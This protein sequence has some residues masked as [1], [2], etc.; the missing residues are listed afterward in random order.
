MTRLFEYQ[1]KTLLVEAGVRVPW[2]R[3]VESV[4]AVEAAGREAQGRVVLKPQLLE[5]GRGRRGLIAAAGN[6]EEAVRRA[7]ELVS[8]SF[9]GGLPRRLLVEEWVT[10]Q[11]EWYVAVVTDTGARRPLLLVSPEGG[12]AVEEALGKGAALRVYLS[13]TRPLRA[14]EVVDALR[15]RYRMESRALAGLARMCAALAEVYRK[16][17]AR[18]VEV[19]PAAWTGDGWVALDARVV[20]DEDAAFRQRDLYRRLGLAEAEQAGGRLPTPLEVEARRIDAEDHRGSVHFVELDPGGARSR[21]QGLVPVAVQ[22][23]GTGV[24][25]TLF[26]ELVPRGYFP[27]NFCDTSGSPPA[28]KVYRA[29]RLVLSQQGFAGF[30]FV[31]CVSSQD[32]GET[33]RGVLRALEEMYP[34]AGGVPGVPTV[35]CFRGWR[36]AQAVELLRRAGIKEGRVKLLGREATERDAVAALDEMVKR[37]EA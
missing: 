17:D 8:G 14:Y 19:N 24:F 37:V 15:R 4:E 2:G 23:V 12:T 7:R 13:A 1:A 32:L 6:A 11:E 33:A 27:I 36:D 31:T 34:E 25:L 21:A 3:V 29:T 30:L 22:T 35:L 20:L 16:T 18:L 10:A 9:W 28:E 5:G 26:D